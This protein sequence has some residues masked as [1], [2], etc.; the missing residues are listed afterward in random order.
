MAKVKICGLRREEDILIVNR[1]LPDYIG[2]VFAE[3]KRKVTKEEARKLKAGLDKS[4]KA[5]GVFVNAPVMDIV[6]LCRENIIDVVQLHGDEEE[7]YIRELKKN[8]SQPVI[9]A[10]RPRVKEDIQQGLA[11]S[12]DYLLLDTYFEG[13]FGGTGKPFDWSMIPQNAE[14]FFL[15]G[16]L[17]SS[18]VKEAIL[19]CHPFCVDISSGVETG[20]FKDESKVKAFIE[21][22]RLAESGYFKTNF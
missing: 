6:E 12:S 2:F 17:N 4:I 7:G 16:G 13:Q 20:G 9:K 21:A 14:N 18:N 11:F 5:A 19:I 22:V 1:Y 3:S 8:I 15:A 10:V